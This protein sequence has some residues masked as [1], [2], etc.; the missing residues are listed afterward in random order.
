MKDKSKKGVRS[1]DNFKEIKYTI[2]L[3]NY[4]YFVLQRKV[5]KEN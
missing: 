2:I 1:K 5:R 4:L 3:V